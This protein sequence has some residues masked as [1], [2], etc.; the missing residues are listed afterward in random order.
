MMRYSVAIPAALADTMQKH[1]LRADGQEDVLLATYLPS[2]GRKRTTALVQT[3][4]FPGPGDRLVHGSASFTSGY[5]LRAANQAQ[6]LGHGLVLLHSHP[7][8]QHWQWLSQPDRDTEAGYLRLA[9][10]I[11]KQPMLG[12]T[13]AGAN[14]AWSARF[15]L[16]TTAQAGA[17]P[18]WAESVRVVGSKLQLTWNDRLRSAPASTDKQRRTVSSWGTDAQASISRLRVLVVGAG[19]VGLDVAQRLAATGLADVGV[20]DFD[21]V[22]QVNLDRMIGATRLDATL[23]RSKAYV[24]ARLMRSAST[25]S[26]FTVHVHEESITDPVGVQTALD[27]DVIISCVDGPW[28]RAVLNAL[29]YT[30]LIP[31]IDGGIAIHTL[32]N[33]RMAGASWRSHTLFPGQPCMVCTRQLNV[34]E[35]TLDKQDLLENPEYIATAGRNEPS[36]QNVAVLSASVSAALLTQFVSL[37]AHPA[38]RGAPGALRHT[39]STHTLE[40]L[41]QHNAPGCLWEHPPRMG[42]GRVAIAEHRDAWRQIITDRHRTR[43][44]LRLRGI[45]ALEALVQRLIGRL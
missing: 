25:A 23:G 35:V 14:S 31:V 10:T 24:A 8:G 5:V 33:G 19:S 12:M 42:D 39:L 22:E 38:G 40:R 20:M 4:I 21:A 45:A 27:Y 26:K 9:A 13:L 1:L 44:S 32:P 36:H 17:E 18:L 7:K 30:D 29:A 11:T 3:V 41:P 16:P 34:G 2:T 6:S 28:A 43:H 15:W 37:V